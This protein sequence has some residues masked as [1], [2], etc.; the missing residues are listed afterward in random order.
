MLSSIYVLIQ[1]A[2]VIAFVLLTGGM[3]YL[4]AKDALRKHREKSHQGPSME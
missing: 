2:S 1:L 4:L 3:V